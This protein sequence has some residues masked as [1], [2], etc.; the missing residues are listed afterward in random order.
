MNGPSGEALIR[1]AFRVQASACDKIGSPFTAR[2]CLLLAE[3]LNAESGIGRLV[4]GWEGDPGPGADSVP[5]RL[6]GALNHLVVVGNDTELA[7]LYPPQGDGGS[8][9]A[10]WHAI[11]GV[12]KRHEAAVAAFLKSAPQTNEVRRSGILLAG[13]SWLA[14]HFGMPLV[15]S[16]VGASAGLN[17]FA[18]RYLL[19]TESFERGRADSPVVLPVEWRGDIPPQAGISVADR[20]G[21]D[22]APID[23]ADDGERAR[24]LSYVWPDQRDRVERT[25]A[26]VGIATANGKASPVTRA[27]AADWLEKRLAQTFE[28]A[29]HVVQHTIAWQ[30]FPDAVKARGE[31]ALAGAGTRAT[32]SRPLARLSLEAD[33]NEPGAAI[34]LTLW[35]GTGSS[36]RTF[37]LGRADYHGRW[38]DWR[39]PHTV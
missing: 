11:S 10:L 2:I 6:C 23:A 33:G 29:V 22:L 34:S 14:A 9:E 12:L 35:D 17:L 24:L 28:N 31:A 5:L 26:A 38:V 30:Y 13:W 8:D 7:S 25:S 3:R 39:N 20:A 18:E 16:E 27:D 15:I 21:C 19:R 36:G 32:E 37:A 1:D 4:F